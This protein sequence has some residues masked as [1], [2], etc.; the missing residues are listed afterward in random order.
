MSSGRKSVKTRLIHLIPVLISSTV[1]II[2]Y[3]WI[4]SIFVERGLNPLDRSLITIAMLS[5]FLIGFFTGR[6]LSF[7]ESKYK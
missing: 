2:S 3:W 1:I 5:T 6:L 4:P 7:L